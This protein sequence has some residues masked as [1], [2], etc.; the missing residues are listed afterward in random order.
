MHDFS[1][2]T[3]PFFHFLEELGGGAQFTPPLPQLWFVL[4]CVNSFIIWKKNQQDLS[5]LFYCKWT[6]HFHFLQCSS[7]A[8]V[9]FLSFLNKNIISFVKKKRKENA[10]NSGLNKKVGG[11]AQC[12][13]PSPHKLWFIFWFVWMNLQF[14]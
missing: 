13:H 11:G 7:S 14:K 5:V 6:Q 1:E 3:K 12:S 4:I 10:L 2:L 9:T 8:H